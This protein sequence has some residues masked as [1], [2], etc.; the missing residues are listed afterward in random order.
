M[1]YGII[2]NFDIYNMSKLFNFRCLCRIKSEEGTRFLYLTN[3][4]P[5][6]VLKK[7]S[8]LIVSPTNLY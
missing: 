4:A 8:H 5:I 1:I 2:G 7:I 6:K 3:L